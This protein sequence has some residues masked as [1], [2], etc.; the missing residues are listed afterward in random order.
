VFK[1]G[2]TIRIKNTPRVTEWFRGQ[3][4][5]IIEKR[6]NYFVV[7]VQDFTCAFHKYNLEFV[8]TIWSVS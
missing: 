8:K 4:G 2:D 6:G 1:I 5:E 7:K 3:T